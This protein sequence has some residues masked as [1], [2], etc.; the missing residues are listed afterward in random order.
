MHPV[1]ALRHRGPGGLD[2]PDL[3][4]RHRC[5]R[6]HHDRRIGADDRRARGRPQAAGA[7]RGAGD[8][9][10]ARPVRHRGADLRRRRAPRRELL[11]CLLG[12]RV[13]DV[14]PHRG[15]HHDRPDRRRDGRRVLRSPGRRE[16]RRDRQRRPDA[17]QQ[18]RPLIPAEH[19]T[20]TGR[21]ECHAG[22]M[23]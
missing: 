11:R 18:A 2:V 15:P 7:H 12:V 20:L 19:R 23:G 3:G 5:R 14:R 13:R 21:A 16:E 8:H 1:G 9:P 10:V 17:P 6:L 4:H 22:T